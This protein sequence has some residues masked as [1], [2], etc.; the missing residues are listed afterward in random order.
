[1]NGSRLPFTKCEDANRLKKD[2]PCDIIHKFQRNHGA[3]ATFL[4][5]NANF[6]KF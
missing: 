5:K 3:H 1:M 2:A 6:I 4:R